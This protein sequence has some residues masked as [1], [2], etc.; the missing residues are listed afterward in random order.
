[1]QGG[2][3]LKR[4]LGDV[5]RA[6]D[7]AHA[8]GKNSVPIPPG[9]ELKP[10][11]YEPDKGQMSGARLFQIQ[12]FARAWQLPPAFLQDLS[13]GTFA[14]GQQQD[15]HLVK[16]LTSQWAKAFEDEANL[17]LFGRGTGGRYV[18]HNLDGPQRGDFKSRI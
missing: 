2:D 7:E 3:G 8:L 9:H 4:E 10:V 17:K 18:E 1:P 5:R 11:G 15:L 6:I 13:R 16:H 12:E 14:N